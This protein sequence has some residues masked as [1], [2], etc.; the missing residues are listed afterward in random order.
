MHESEKCRSVMSDSSRPQ[1]L[2]PTGL[3]HRGIF[4][5]RIL[6]WGATAFSGCLLSKVPQQKQKSPVFIFK[7]ETP[8]HSPTTQ[9]SA[10][11]R[12]GDSRRAAPLSAT[13]T[14]SLSFESN[15][16][17]SLRAWPAQAFYDGLFSAIRDEVRKNE[18]KEVI[19][20]LI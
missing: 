9:A 19:F 12:K 5:A 6:E 20:L 1:G 18:N 15:P 16:D 4:Q 17:Q 11:Q 14:D 10:Q 8:T 13:S 2:Q 7:S 3:F